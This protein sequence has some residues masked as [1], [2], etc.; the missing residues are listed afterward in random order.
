V[1]IRDRGRKGGDF[2]LHYDD[3]D[4]LDDIL[5]KLSEPRSVT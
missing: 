2:I 1:T 5:T 4:Q 3:L